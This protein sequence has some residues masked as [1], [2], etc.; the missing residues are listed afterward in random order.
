[1]SWVLVENLSEKKSKL[2]QVKESEFS[3]TPYLSWANFS[4]PFV[5]YDLVFT[6]VF[7]L[8]Y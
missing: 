8:C 3:Y 7:V 2:K 5:L 4:V 6:S 1:M